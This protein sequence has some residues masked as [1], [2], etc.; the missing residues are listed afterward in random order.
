MNIFERG[1]CVLQCRYINAVV[2][3]APFTPSE[4]FLRLLPLGMPGAVYHG[5]TT[6]IPLT[7]DPYIDPKKLGIFKE[8]GTHPFQ[9]VNAGEIVQRI[10]RSREAFE[11]RQRAK[12]LKAIGEE[13]LKQKEQQ[14][15]TWPA[16]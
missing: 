2:F 11:A 5:P 16:N 9:H 6:F 7:Y 15:V 13:N 12:L 10:L 14:E 3:G 8:I 1:L 4:P